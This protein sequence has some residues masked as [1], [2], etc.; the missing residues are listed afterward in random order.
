MHPFLLAT[1]ALP[2]VIFSSTPV[3]A[4]G[5][6]LALSLNSS[7]VVEGKTAHLKLAKSGGNGKAVT[8]AWK[9]SDGRSGS[10]TLGSTGADIP[11]PTTDDEIVNGTR[12]ISVTA[13]ATS[14]SVHPSASAAVT[15]TDNDVAAPQPTIIAV[16]SPI[17]HESDGK[18]VVSGTIGGPAGTQQLTWTTNDKGTA[19]KGVDYPAL[20]SG[21]MTVTVPGS[22]TFSIPYA[23]NSV[24]N[25]TKT[26]GFD[27]FTND[28]SAI[29]NGFVT[30][31]DDDAATPPAPTPLPQPSP[32]PVPVAG[33][34]PSPTLEGL[35][36]IDDGIDEAANLIQIP[37][38]ASAAPDT[39]GAF[40][41]ICLPGQVLADDPIMYP[42]QPGKSHL[43]QFYG[44]TGANAYSTYD[45]LRTSG[46]ST[47]MDPLNRSA[48]WIPALIGRDGTVRKPDYVQVYYKRYPASSWQCTS[49]KVGIACVAQPNGFRW[50]E[51]RNMMN[52][53]APK[54]GNVRFFCDNNSGDHD[55]LTDA[56][57]S[58]PV[59]NHVFVDIAGP[60]CWDGKNLDSPDHRSHV[61]Y[62]VDS[63]MGYPMCPT[64]HP[65]LI[66]QFN[67][68][69]SYTVRAGDDWTQYRYSSDAM[70]PTE[71]AGATF[72]AD[73]FDGWK[74]ET[75]AR[76][77][78][79]CLNRLLNCAM[80]ILG[81]GNALKQVYPF[82]WTASPVSI[83]LA[84]V[85][86]TPVR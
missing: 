29:A 60:D 44:N 42:G 33:W 1:A 57:V 73:L 81:D 17:I 43:H 7:A 18:A 55:N 78:D 77:T 64:T 35:A 37:V 30:V 58:C 34:V 54:T 15:V 14:G 40:R 53:S 61:A 4:A 27:V 59:G 46:D 62:M 83:P 66:P 19:T 16:Q 74:K 6:P 26:V 2:P 11:I 24:P 75:K 38:P 63:H 20:L 86:Q 48:Y 47:C 8:V 51:G 67:L 13:T 72:H 84:Q 85:P 71:K 5:K 32:T 39:L 9:T 25:D 31:M 12:S 21:G 69:T 41:F 36:P 82:S 50:I 49:G 79:G 28:K 70:T 22:F 56:A 10:L 45:S 68:G 52:L 3:M 80:G 76:W 65:Y 23:N